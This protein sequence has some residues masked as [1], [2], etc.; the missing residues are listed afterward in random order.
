V[1]SDTDTD[2]DSD[3]DT[4]TDTDADSD[5]DADTEASAF[6]DD[7][8]LADGPTLDEPPVPKRSDYACGCDAPVTPVGW[9]ALLA[10]IPAMR[11]RIG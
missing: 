5:A 1:Q 3:A 7:D 2:T 10:V 4:D 6:P 9:L 8:V 11:R